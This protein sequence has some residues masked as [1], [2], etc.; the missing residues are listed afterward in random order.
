MFSKLT[1]LPNP[2]ATMIIIP[3]T[4]PATTTAMSSAGEQA[5]GHPGGAVDLAA[6]VGVGRRADRQHAQGDRV[7][8][9]QAGAE[10]EAGEEDFAGALRAGAGG[11]SRHPS[12][13]GLGLGGLDLVT[14][15]GVGVLGPRADRDPFWCVWVTGACS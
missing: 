4:I 15:G 13:V 9:G 3:M 11:W 1:S 10:D 14:V 2:V 12:S 6:G 8:E 5:A 7:D